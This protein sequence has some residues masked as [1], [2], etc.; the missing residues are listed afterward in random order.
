MILLETQASHP[1]R[2]PAAPAAP[3]S[4][5]TCLSPLRTPAAYTHT[6]ARLPLSRRC[7]HS[8]SQ[9]VNSPK[10]SSAHLPHSVRAPSLYV[11]PHRAAECE[12][13]PRIS[14]VGLHTNNMHSCVIILSCRA[15]VNAT[16]IARMRYQA[17][18]YVSKTRLRLM[19]TPVPRTYSSPRVSQSGLSAA[20]LDLYI[21]YLFIDNE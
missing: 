11:A 13:I 15:I 19:T 18:E 10:S 2:S 9:R 14:K 20:R 3:R 16:Y 6:R 8:H 5:I 17:A 1:V 12:V 21:H 7:L 4:L